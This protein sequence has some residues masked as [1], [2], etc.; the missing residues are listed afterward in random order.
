MTQL[1]KN[2]RRLAQATLRG[3]ALAMDQE[4]DEPDGGKLD[5]DF[6]AKLFDYLGGLIDADDLGTIKE[7]LSKYT[8]G[9]ELAADEPPAFPGRPRVGGGMDPL[10]SAQDRRIAL[11][12]HGRP[13]NY[14]PTQ[15]E[16]DGFARR[17]PDAARIGIL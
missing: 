14:G 5:T 9:R 13:F 12:A 6:V 10:G 11:D 8:A 17:W 4:S 3:M 16:T 2:E 1:T 7:C 15:A